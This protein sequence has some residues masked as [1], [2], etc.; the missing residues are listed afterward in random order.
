MA[1]NISKLPKMNPVNGF[2]LGTAKAAIRY[3]DRK[4]LVLMEI[5]SGSAVAATFTKNA[6]CAAP[7]IM[8][9][10]HLADVEPRYLL[11]NT[12]SANAGTGE[13][14]LKD[15][16]RCC[17]LV[18]DITDVN[19]KQVL[20]FST[21]VI[22][23]LLPLEKIEK[24]LPSAL[25]A[26]SESG[27]EDAAYGI[28][29]TDTVPKGASEII[30]IGG[31]DVVIT[32]IS[33]GSGMIKPN[34]ATMLGYIATDAQIQSPLLQQVLSTAVKN[35]FN[36]ITVDGDTSTNDSVVLVATGKSEAVE[37]LE[38]SEELEIFSAAIARVS[39]ILAQAIVRDGEG[40]TKFISINIQN[41]VS[42][43]EAEQVAFTIAHSPLVKTALFA[44]DPNWGRILAAVGRSGVENLDISKISL[45]IG[46]TCLIKDGNPDPAYTEAAGQKE[47]DKDE[48][49][50]TVDLQ[51]GEESCTVWTCDFSYDYVKIN[52]EY[53]S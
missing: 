9:K 48:I 30:K 13:Q 8:A 1:V 18:A 15:A 7:V 6:F 19:S 46:T 28:M 5:A 24:G 31:E 14:G 26:L 39:K 52:A 40:A 41:S 20:P 25:A 53:R 33:K 44:S 42:E 32:G 35:T 10:K 3:E 47:M 22:G 2:K 29:T 16:K 11:V 36:R 37:I 21:G 27:W 49:D 4:D 45:F 51:R 50:I 43:A 12:G 34:M 17:E 23:E 38:G